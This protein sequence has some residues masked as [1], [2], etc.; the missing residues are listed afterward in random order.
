MKPRRVVIT[1]IGLITPL[2]TGRDKNWQR[3]SE[4]DSGITTI[5][6]FDTSNLPVKIAGI[7]RDY[8]PAETFG[9]RE[10]DRLD[11]FLQFAVVAAREAVSDSGLVITKDLSYRAGTVIGSGIGGINTIEKQ[12]IALLDGGFKQVKPYFIPSMLINLA[13]GMVSIEFSLKGPSMSPSTACAAGSHAIGLAFDL[14]R[15]DKADIMVCG[16]SESSITQLGIAGFSKLRALSSR[17]DSPHT[18]SRPFD[19]DRDG[20]VISE[21]SGIIVIEELESAKKRNAPIYAEIIGFGM[22]SDAF[23][24]TAPSEDGEGAVICMRNALSDAGIEPEDIDYINAHGTSTYLNDITET[25]AIR[26]VFGKD[27]HVNISSNKSMIGHLLGAAGGVETA[28]TALTVKN[29]YI[30]PTINLFEADPQCDLN[31]TP[32]K[33]ISREIEYAINN[34]FG[35]GGTNTTLVLKKYQQ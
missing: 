24:I 2:G 29:D 13:A 10:A 28:F 14:I 32:N 11:R 34:S 7:V 15:N 12:H 3:A 5:D 22:S 35:F 30:L 1:G 25:K 31:Y 20:F 4:G 19:K 8:D 33:G 23:H 9:L 26:Q 27:T 6:I 17:N 21:G 16:G 18:A